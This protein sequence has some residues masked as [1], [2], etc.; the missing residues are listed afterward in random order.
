MSNIISGNSYKLGEGTYF[1]HSTFFDKILFNPVEGFSLHNNLKY[2]QKKKENVFT[3]IATPRYAFAREAFSMKGDIRYKYGKRLKRNSIW[4]EGGRYIF[5]YNEDRPIDMHVNAFINLFYHRNYI[6]L[7]EKDYV[8]LGADLSVSQNVKIRPLAEFANRYALDNNTSQSWFPREDRA[9][10]PNIPLNEE[11]ELPIAEEQ[12]A[13][14]LGIEVEAKP[15][16]KYRIENGRK[17]PVS[18][19]SPTLLFHYKKGVNGLL[20]SEVNFDLFEVTFISKFNIGAKGLVNVK[21][22]TGIFFNDNNLN[23]ADFKH[24]Q[25]NRLPFVT[26]DPVGS[27]RLLEYYRYSTADK[28]LAL[29]AHYQFRKF[30]VTQFPEAWLIGMKENLFVNYLAT[31]TSDNY[32]ELGYSID[33]IFR[34]FR[35]EAAFSFQDGKYRDFGVLIGIASN[36]EDI[37][38]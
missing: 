31:P 10:D 36:L 18:T 27:F 35:V 1:S 38:D 34:I 16:Q 12:K 4:L 6:S 19:S 20:D 30:L 28:F 33:N 37:F 22:N 11:R 13:M 9:Y 21:A 14:L 29:H 23:F 17:A 3:I 8:Q 26:T 5:Q 24:F 15:W 7:Y 2:S 25:G 32:V